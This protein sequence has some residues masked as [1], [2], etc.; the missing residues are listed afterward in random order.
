MGNASKF[1]PLKWQ[2]FVHHEGQKFAIELSSYMAHCTPPARF[3]TEAEA[4]QFAKRVE[5]YLEDHNGVFPNFC[6][7]EWGGGMKS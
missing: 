1:P 3:D 2:I 6:S 5:K 4:D 7:Q